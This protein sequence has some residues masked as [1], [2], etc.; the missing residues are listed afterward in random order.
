VP[1]PLSGDPRADLLQE[2]IPH[3]R[4]K[5]G[6]IDL[7]DFPIDPP[8]AARVSRGGG[9]FGVFRQR[10]D[11][12]HAGEDWSGP[13]GQEN[14]G[15]AVFSIGHGIVTYAQPLGWGRDQGVV[16]VQH[17]DPDGPAFLSFYGHLAPE[18]VTL[19]PGD[20]VARGDLVGN[21]G[22]PRSF[23][24]LHW[25]VRTQA[26]Y[27]TLTGY[28]PDDPT[29][30]GWLPP[31]RTVWAQRLLAQ[32]GV[33]WVSPPSD[34]DP[35]S[36][37]IG[38]ISPE[39]GLLW[40][41]NQLATLDLAQGGAPAPLVLAG[42][43]ASDPSS[44]ALIHANTLFVVDGRRQLLAYSLPDLVPKWELAL[45][46]PGRA[47][48]SPHHSGGVLVNTPN[49]LH[50]VT[51]T[52]KLLWSAADISRPSSWVLDEATETI[53]FTTGGTNPVEMA[54]W[55]AVGAGVPEQITAVGGDLIRTGD[56]IWLYAPNQGLYQWEAATAS[57]RLLYPL[58]Q[59]WGEI[60]PLPDE[61]GVLLAHRDGRHSRLLRF[62]GDG[63]LLW[64]GGVEEVVGR[65]WWLAGLGE[66]LFLLVEGGRPPASSLLL[67]EVDWRDGGLV[68]VWFGGTRTAVAGGSWFTAVDEANQLL[69]NIGGGHLLAFAPDTREE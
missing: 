62:A 20:C 35:F 14:L 17:H 8:D 38:A 53:Y 45:P 50:A 43:E 40:A 52:G 41:G 6:L 34:V 29:A 9:D 32:P 28:W 54:L 57:L 51:N 68:Q 4:N 27:A 1:L 48:L 39:V 67:Y 46:V 56:T 16:I 22:Q 31:S 59:G 61:S 65:E 30:E 18:S 2:P 58:A 11:K 21:I 33:L 26:P 36:Q 55:Q 69:L 15:T 25:E 5:C 10:F 63:T 47:T 42:R 66:R 12:F 64:E 37:F 13:D 23:P 24:H 19:Q 7:L 44:S 49:Q 3:S 60:A